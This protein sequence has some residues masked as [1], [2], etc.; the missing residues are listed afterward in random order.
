L[1][2][3]KVPGYNEI[4]WCRKWVTEREALIREEKVN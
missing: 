1:N 2:G 4:K 3:L